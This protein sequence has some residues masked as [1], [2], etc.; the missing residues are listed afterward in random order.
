MHF[1]GGM[2]IAY[3]LYRGMGAFPEFLR[4]ASGWGN[5]LFAFALATVV[6]VF[7]EFAELASDVFL[8][9]TIQKSVHETMRDL[10]ADVLGALL[11]LG[12][13]AFCRWVGAR[14]GERVG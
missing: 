2:A 13:L 11:A 9:S 1:S 7:W 14:K 3:F 5:Y 8:G 12:I 6:G 10:I 4:V